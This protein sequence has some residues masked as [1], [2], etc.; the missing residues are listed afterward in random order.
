MI[1]CGVV[2]HEDEQT[3]NP[4]DTL[5]SFA[6]SSMVR[7][8]EPAGAIPGLPHRP[9]ASASVDGSAARYRVVWS[10]TSRTGSVGPL[11]RLV[12]SEVD[13]TAVRS[14]PVGPARRLPAPR[15]AADPLPPRVG[16]ARV[17]PRGRDRV[18]SHG[19]DAMAR[20]A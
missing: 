11:N 16:S 2:Q 20:T 12:M 6:R 9:D 15:S 19:L 8:T 14:G 4:S 13:V 5:V 17:S 18:S 3:C 10:M 1:E 7:P